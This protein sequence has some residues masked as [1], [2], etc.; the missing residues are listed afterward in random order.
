M[1]IRNKTDQ[2]REIVVGDF[3]ALVES[4]ETV[5]VPDE[6][7]NGRPATGDDPTEPGF[8]AG[9][10]GLLEQPDVWEKASGRKAASTTEET[11]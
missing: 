10:S 5:D 2:A 9:L 8:D 11:E 1:Q 4:G 7:A 6:I 3:T